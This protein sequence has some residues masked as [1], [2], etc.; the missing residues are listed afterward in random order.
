MYTSFD[1]MPDSA[2]VWIYQSSREISSEEQKAIA[3]KS[4]GFLNE[5]AAHGTG[6]QA[7]FKFSHNHFLILA[8]DENVHNASGCSIDASVSF[9]KSIAQEYNLDF[10]D[11]SKIAFIF[12]EELFFE[13]INDIKG[14]VLAGEISASALIFNNAIT[15]KKELENNWIIPA[16]DS[17]AGKH[18]KQ[19]QN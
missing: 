12:N 18:F 9:V 8:V 1:N 19:L 15:L 5:W 14:K 17:W 6:L 11:R 4:T 16:V 10:F 7:S 2:R 13:S 3:T